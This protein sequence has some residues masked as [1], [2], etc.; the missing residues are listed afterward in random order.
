VAQ[1]GR[2]AIQPCFWI[3]TYCTRPT[4]LGAAQDA[5]QSQGHQ[6]GRREQS[7][8][9][10]GKAGRR[11]EGR[12]GMKS[13]PSPEKKGGRR[14]GKTKSAPGKQSRHRAYTRSMPYKQ[15]SATPKAR[16]ALRFTSRP[17]I[18]RALRGNRTNRKLELLIEVPG[19][20]KIRAA[21]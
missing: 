1:N 12:C 2:V 11:T 20:I 6:I 18:D 17:K 9:R 8:S 19:R 13:P 16:A 15:S 7:R 21:G 10:T 3:P 5:G 4:G 14:G